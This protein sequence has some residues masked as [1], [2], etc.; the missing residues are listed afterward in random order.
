M[1]L[2]R[3]EILILIDH[4]M[5][6]EFDLEDRIDKFKNTCMGLMDDDLFGTQRKRY[7]VMLAEYR[8]R[9]NE[10]QTELEKL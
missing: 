5:G 1:E 4:Y 6:L 7:K 10:L 3:N 8:S 9:I 2:T